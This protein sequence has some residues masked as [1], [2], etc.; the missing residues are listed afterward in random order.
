MKIAVVFIVGIL[1]L[2]ILR[3]DNTALAVFSGALGQGLGFGQQQLASNFI[4]EI[5]IL[6]EWSLTVGD[7]IEQEVGKAGI[8]KEINMRSSALSTFDDG[9]IIVPNEKFIIARFT[10]VT[11][12]NPHQ[13]CEARFCVAYHSD[14]HKIPALIEMAIVKL[15]AVLKFQEPRNCELTGLDGRGVNFV[16]RYWVA[17][18]D[19]GKISFSSQV[20]ILIWD[21]LQAVCIAMPYLPPTIILARNTILTRNTGKKHHDQTNYLLR[22]KV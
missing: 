8:L 2:N 9:E 4:P 15:G 6:V 12:T 21:A 20:Y 22:I 17:E 14:F 7:C 19:D 1:L 16:A 13:H 5:I 3:L 18:I 10:N 11:K